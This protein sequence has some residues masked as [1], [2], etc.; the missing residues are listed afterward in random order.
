[1]LND[2]WASHP[3]WASEDSGFV[4]HRKNGYEEG[5]HR[6]EEERHDYDFYIELNQKCIQ[7]L[8]PIAQQMLSLP[9]AERATFKLPPGLGGQSTSIYKRV[10]KKIYG[11]E[12]GADVVSEM[13][14]S[15]FA[16]V[17]IVMARLR[18]KDEEWRFTQREWEKVWQ[19]QTDSMHLKSLDHMGIQVKSM[20]KKNFSTK[21]LLDSIH[22]KHEA[23]ERARISK[24][25]D[26]H[27]P[28]Y[29]YLFHFEDQGVLLDVLRFMVIFAT[30]GGQHNA[31]ERRRL[32]EFFETFVP[33]FFDLPED[34][35]AEK[36]ADIEQESAAEDDDE[37]Q[38]VADVANGRTKR[39]GKKP[40]L[41]RG[42]LDPVRNGNKARG[43][44]EDS[45]AASVSKETTPDIGSANEDEMADVGD[46][47]G[48]PN[49][50][51]DR[52]MPTV[53]QATIRQ[54]DRSLLDDHGDLRADAPFPRKSYNLFCNQHIFTFVSVLEALYRRVKVVKGSSASV[55]EELRREKADKPAKTLGLVSNE[56]S[57]FDNIAPDAYWSRTVTLVE[58]FIN[59]EIDENRYQDILRRYYLEHGW[60]LYTIQDLLR[61]ICRSGLA[62]NN[63]DAKGEKTKEL[64]REYFLTRQHAE[65]SY[66]TEI[67]AR[68]FA[69]KCIKD[70]DM[71]VVGWVS[72]P[73]WRFVSKDYTDFA[74]GR[75]LRRGKPPFAFC[76]AQRRHSSWMNWKRANDGNTTSRR[77]P[78]SSRRKALIEAS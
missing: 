1:V 3:T 43:Q 9:P 63:P 37:D 78:V 36:L 40:D 38:P 33:S 65:T 50:T 10:L 34:K 64:L 44:K 58:D 14:T 19:A 54:G 7:L 16:V 48:V 30:N 11:M 18:Q 68:R 17:P 35:V 32:I 74:P 71:F 26:A 2:D 56:V 73:G 67:S 13:F 27:E 25:K 6:I 23:Q 5:L 45:A 46:D 24:G 15:P 31:A 28:R 62:C 42:V 75:C 66:Q 8:E 49:V 60:L 20:D 77:G 21:H 39:N 59:S 52:W 55:G 76:R 57:Y 51:N 12:R 53:P 61:N 47:A 22:A 69:E 29:Q 41:L 70:G 72:V 4:A